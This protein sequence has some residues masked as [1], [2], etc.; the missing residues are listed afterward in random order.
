MT[1]ACSRSHL[2]HCR[3]SILV[4][5]LS[6]T[7]LAQVPRVLLPH[8]PVLPRLSQSSKYDT[9]AVMRSMVG[10]LWMIDA[11]FKSAIYIRNN[12]GI[13]SLTV[14]PIL[15]ISNGTRYR[16]SEVKLEPLGTAVANINEALR[17]KNIAP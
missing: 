9:P 13:S 6:L 4:V 15:Y 2:F 12:V 1:F 16:L 11:N 5:L 17:E 7:S 10:G 8:K 3:L 14:T